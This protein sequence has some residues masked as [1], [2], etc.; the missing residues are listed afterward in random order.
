VTHDSAVARRAERRLRI[1]QGK[2]HE[3]A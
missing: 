1:K 2:V 3:A